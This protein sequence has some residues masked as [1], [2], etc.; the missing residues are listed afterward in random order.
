MHVIRL[1]RAWEVRSLSVSRPTCDD[2]ARATKRPAR[3]RIDLPVDDDA[4]RQL[5]DD[6]P[7]GGPAEPNAEAVCSQILLSRKFNRPS[8]LD[9]GLRVEIHLQPA[10]LVA[11]ALLN[12]QTLTP[13]GEGEWLAGVENRLADYNRLDLLV[14]SPASLR[15]AGARLLI[16]DP[17]R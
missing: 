9:G 12:G 14:A 1:N 11:M 6:V 13:D 15:K 4:W 3:A 17:T 5:C 2:V 10:S 7:V 8:N 16:H